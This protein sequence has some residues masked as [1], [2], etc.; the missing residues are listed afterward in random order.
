MSLRYAELVKGGMSEED[1][2][3]ATTTVD[4]SVEPSRTKQSFA[5]EADINFLM[6]RFLRTGEFPT[7]E[8][9]GRVGTFGDFSDG[10]DF[11]MALERVQDAERQFKGLEARV[12]DRFNNDPAQMLD[13]LSRDGNREEA[14][15]LGLVPDKRAQER[16]SERTRV[17]DLRQAEIE[18]AER[19]GREAV[20]QQ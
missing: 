19:R 12:R 11:Q 13:F 2:L 9:T 7:P 18:A 6:G 5:K 14:V 16:R 3:R 10:V 20:K 8:E 17:Q 1:A 15:R 4:C